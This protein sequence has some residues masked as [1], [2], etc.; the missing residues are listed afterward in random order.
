MKRSSILAILAAVT[1]ILLCSCGSLLPSER[2]RSE[3][4]RATENL[5]V[6]Q[7]RTIRRVLEVTP[8]NSLAGTR[9][10]PGLTGSRDPVVTVTPLREDLSYTTKTRTGAGSANRSEASLV[11]SIPLGVKILLVAAG[12]GALVLA[13]RYAVKSVRGTAIGEAIALADSS[14]SA[15]IRA[16][17]HA[18]QVETDPATMARLNAEIAESEAE[19]GRLAAAAYKKA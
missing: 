10:S 9:V 6:E 19:R 3:S 17:R 12:T 1:S 14:L 7:E 13:V 18:A 15:S 2:Q 4:V 11:E 8:Q 5:A 16:K